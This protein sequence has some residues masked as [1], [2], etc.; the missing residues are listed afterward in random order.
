MLQVINESGE[1]DTEVLRHIAQFLS[2]HGVGIQF[3]CQPEDAGV[4]AL[5][6]EFQ[7]LMAENHIEGEAD[8]YEGKLQ[9]SLLRL[10]SIT[11]L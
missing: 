6:K 1:E 2:Y 3:R 5:E 8:D 10:L 11:R 7:A 4:E 9:S